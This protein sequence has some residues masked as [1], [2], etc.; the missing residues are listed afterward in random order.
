MI[1]LGLL[2]AGVL[3]P[4]LL[5]T[6]AEPYRFSATGDVIE[7]EED[8]AGTWV[9]GWQ[10]GGQEAEVRLGTVELVMR[11]SLSTPPLP[12]E[13]PTLPSTDATSVGA[14]TRL[15]T[16]EVPAGGVYLLEVEPVGDATVT[17]GSFYLTG[18]PESFSGVGLL[19]IV[20]LVGGAALLIA[21]VVQVLQVRADRV[22][23]EQTGDT[24]GADSLSSF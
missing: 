24:G 7:L 8:Q 10:G 6:D 17:T 9:L 20:L 11:S 5:T 4:L 21:W 19:R 23:S 14:L 2:A 22:R 12:T 1:A 3:L 15:A 13:Q 18:P 16:V